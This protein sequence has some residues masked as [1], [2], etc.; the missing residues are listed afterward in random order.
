MKFRILFLFWWLSAI[1]FA[2]DNRPDLQSKR[3]RLTDTIAIDTVSI[4]PLGFEIRTTDGQK[5]DSLSYAVDF[6]TGLIYP[7]TELSRQQDSLVIIY[8]P[9]PEF[10]TR[11]YFELDQSIVVQSTGDIDKL[12][13]LQQAGDKRDFN[14]L[15]G[16]NTVGSLS[17][18]VTVGN[19][20]NAVVNSQLDLQI[21]GQLSENVSIR[22]SIQD[23]NIPTQEGGYSQSIDEFDQI[24]I[25]LFGK[26]WNIRAGDVDLINTDSYFAK[27][28]KKVQGISLGGTVEHDNGAKT[29]AYLSGAL[30]RGVF[31]RSQFTAQEG[32]QGPYKLIGPNGE[33]FI[34]IISGSERV[35]VNGLLLERGENKDYVIDYNAGEIRFNPTYP[36]TTNMRITVEYQYTDQNYTRF[37]GYGGGK[38]ER[39]KLDIGAYVYTE[40]DAKNQPLQQS[41]TEEQVEI[42]AAAGDDREAMQAPSAVPDSFSENKIL[43]KKETIDGVEVFVFSSEPEDELFNVRFSLVGEN[44]GNYV[45]SS[46]SAINTIFEYVPPQNGIPQGNY[47]PIV[48]LVPPVNLHVGGVN[49]SYRPTERTLIDFEIAGSYNDQNRFSTLDDDDNDG[50]AAHLDLRQGLTKKGDSLQLDLIAGLDYI[51]QDFRTVEILYNVE[52]NRDW[53]LTN[54]MGDQR[55]VTG[56]FELGHLGHGKARYQF[57]NLDFSENFSGYRHLLNGFYRVGRW[58]FLVNGSVLNSESDVEDSSFFR[59]DVNLAYSWDKA[60]A[61]GKYNTEDNEVVRVANDSLTPIS[62]RLQS[63]EV[64]TGVGDSTKVF[65]ELGYRY[66]ANDSVRMNKL[67]GVNSSNTV[68]LKSRI[69]NKP[70]AQLSVF[71]NYRVLEDQDGDD[72]DE[73]SLNSR[74]VYNQS[75]LGGGIRW[76]TVY[77]SNNGVLAQQEFTYIQ[78]EPGQGIYTWIDYNENGIQELEE[79]EVAQFTDQAEYIRVLLP[80]QVFVKT[81][82]NRFSQTL[83]LNPQAWSSSEG[84][85]KFLSHF[86]NQTTYIVDRKVRRDDELNIS[87][88]DNGEENQL[89]LSLNVRNSLFYNRGKQRYTTS[90]TFVSS[91]TNNLISLGL[92]QNSLKSHQLNFTHKLKQAWLVNLKGTL[93]NN[94]S[95]SQNFANRNFKIEN[96]LLG[97]KLSY[98]LNRQTRFDVFYEYRNK[99][100]QLG[101]METLDQH[102]LGLSFAYNNA[103]KISISGEFNYIDNQFEGSAFSPVAYQ[104]LEGLQPGTNFTWNLLLQKR[105]TKFLD[106]NLTYFGRKSE[107]SE[108]I[109]TGSVQLR[110][111]F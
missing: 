95:E 100:N 83:I 56:G 103:E 108:T 59:A 53:N 10:L 58:Q 37:I 19:N 8:R 96:Y 47:E 13:A 107:D 86:Y 111:Y 34:L 45:I 64:Y 43:Y 80:N 99:E 75:V 2:Q 6:K 73:K 71:V 82:D 77:E 38:Y 79:F 87:P 66:Q 30:V 98:L 67:T 60:W 31:Q 106:A 27:F 48:Q 68:F 51:N 101:E 55:F 14:P 78:V 32:N 17:R 22:A 39:S 92:Q 18:G 1:A 49:G 110:A 91:S 72:E 88:F 29:S 105:I 16:L 70:N 41:L 89:G 7:N 69:L 97:P 93:G 15:E 4:N 65:A 11:D 40:N 102:K 85:K 94:K 35:Y 104:M 76:T 63:Y 44:Q 9:Y 62:Q 52:F 81:R 46:I 54:P 50:F 61:G 5:V 90:Y 21:T 84:F 20:Q 109:H 42:L 36:I 24:F 57:Q 23:A 25:E 28:T 33:L 12:Y 3:V 74:L 26:N